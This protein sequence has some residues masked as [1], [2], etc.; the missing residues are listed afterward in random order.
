MARINR[1]KTPAKTRTIQFNLV[2]IQADPV[3]YKPYSPVLQPHFALIVEVPVDE[4]EM[5]NDTTITLNG[6]MSILRNVSTAIDT[7]HHERQIEVQH[8]YNKR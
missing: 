4:S 5:I 2:Q 6:L 8:I 3:Q 1:S 7:M